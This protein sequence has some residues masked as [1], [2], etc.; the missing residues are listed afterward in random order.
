MPAFASTQILQEIVA[1][2]KQGNPIGIFS[3]CTAN[4]YV[5]KASMAQAKAVDSYLLIEATCNQVNQYGGYTG[6]T[7]EDFKA[8][9]AKLADQLGF[10]IDRILLGGDHLGPH[11]WKSERAENAMTKAKELVRDYVLAGFRKIHLDTSM[12]CDG[13]I[14]GQPLD[15]ELV[16]NR[17]AS[18]GEVAEAAYLESPLG[19][20]PVYV[21]GT[22]VPAPG[23]VDS[24]DNGMQI[25]SPENV[26]LTL[27]T[28]ERVF[29]QRGLSEAWDRVIAL[30]VQPGVE[31]GNSEVHDYNPDLARPLSQYIESVPGIVYEAHSTDYQ[32]PAMLKQ[33]VADHFAILKVGPALTYAFREAVF[34]LALMEREWLQGRLDVSLSNIIDIVD[35]EMCQDRKYWESYYPGENWEQWFARKYSYSDR[36]RYYWPNIRVDES[37]RQLYANLERFKPPLTLISQYLP[38]Q[39]KKI[40]EGKIKNHPEDLIIDRIQEVLSIYRYACGQESRVVA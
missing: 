8:Y 31:F 12:H 40:R 19:S 23:G 25:T 17:A 28:F 33:M 29:M 30:V 18:L 13:D 9:V 6:M 27:K 26:H 21:I 32:K 35:Y 34:A 7:P 15:L 2:Q 11:P 24:T 10:P 20:K 1:E 16:A 3:I 37:M 38:N 5:L 4:P 39:Y 14:Q 22:E 36:I